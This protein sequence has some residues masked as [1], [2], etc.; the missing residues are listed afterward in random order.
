MATVQF[1]NRSIGMPADLMFG[2]DG[3]TIC[4]SVGRATTS[5]K[6]KETPTFLAG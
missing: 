4:A 1:S 5:N 3:A 2:Q 6:V